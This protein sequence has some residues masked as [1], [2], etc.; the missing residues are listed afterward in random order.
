MNGD[1]LTPVQVFL[2]ALAIS[3]LGGLAALLHSKRSL[4]PRAIIAAIVYSG[5]LGTIIALLWYNKF[6]DDGN[7]Y[8]VLGISGLAGIGG[9]S[10]IDLIVAILK[11]GGVNIIIKPKKEEDE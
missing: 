8:F 3:S 10:A 6:R 2:S 4:T 5:A 7:I 1:D 9:A 11:K